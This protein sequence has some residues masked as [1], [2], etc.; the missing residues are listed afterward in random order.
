MIFAA[1]IDGN[2]VNCAEWFDSWE[3]F[4]RATFS[5]AIELIALEVKTRKGWKVCRI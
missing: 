5:P 4:H 3:D 2:G 1:W